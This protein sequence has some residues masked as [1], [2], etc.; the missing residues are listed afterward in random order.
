M[1]GDFLAMAEAP[2]NA[3]TIITNPPYG[4]QGRWARQF[5]EHSLHLMMPRGGLVAMLLRCDFDHGLTRRHLFYDCTFFAAKLAL[6]SRPEW[7]ADGDKGPRQNFSWFV[8]DAE[9]R[10]DAAIRWLHRPKSAKAKLAA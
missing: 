6:T 10:G 7:F 9:H 3:A 4:G 1:V 8:W 2:D 5:I